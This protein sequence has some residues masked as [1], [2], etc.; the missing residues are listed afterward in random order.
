LLLLL[1]LVSTSR[2]RAPHLRLRLHLHLRGRGRGRGRFMP[3]AEMLVVK[4]VYLERCA[5]GGERGKMMDVEG[6]RG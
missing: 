3:V 5:V 2:C 1:S 4:L 6:K